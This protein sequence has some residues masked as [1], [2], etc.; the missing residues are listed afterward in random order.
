MTEPTTR[1]VTISFTVPTITHAVIGAIL[2]AAAGAA[3]WVHFALPGGHA[4]TTSGLANLAGCIV[5]AY[6]LWCTIERD[7]TGV[8]NLDDRTTAAIAEAEARE[9]RLHAKI[10]ESTCAMLT[11][12]RE[13]S[14]AINENRAAIKSMDDAVTASTVAVEA[15]TA[16]VKEC[17]GAI[18]A[19]QNCYLR[20]GTVLVLPGED[21][22]ADVGS[23][24]GKE[25]PRELPL[26]A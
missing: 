14:E 3:Y 19:L 4:F 13:I 5:L 2:A 21:E 15:A 24:R 25:A 12:L 17:I 1:R 10:D 11:T 7:R 20:E 8:V 22:P 26:P 18:V 23:D 6:W 16:A 9:A